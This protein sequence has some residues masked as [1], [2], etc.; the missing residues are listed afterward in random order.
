V[1]REILLT[2]ERV[3]IR[4]WQRRDYQ[5]VE[6]WPQFTDPLSLVWNLPQ[7]MSERRGGWSEPDI[8]CAYAV[9]NLEGTVVGRIS[10]REIDRAHH[11]A[12]LGISFGPPYV[13][14][15]LGTEAL[16]CFLDGYFGPLGFESMV[17]DVAAPNVRA[18]RS[19]L[20]LGFRITGRHWRDAGDQITRR[21]DGKIPPELEQHFRW[22]R[23]SLWIEF[24]DME[25]TR[26][27]WLART[28]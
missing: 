2:A 14:Q 16:A 7:S 28:G 8:R 19:Y 24:F 4:P 1:L 13:G 25:L 11:R 15:G 20:K 22:G 23:R 5:N 3:R 27:E 21:L 17:L 6:S 10:L 18:V 12:R 9:E 26:P